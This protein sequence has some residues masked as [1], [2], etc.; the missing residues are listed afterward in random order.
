VDDCIFCK[1]ASEEIPA[2][3]IW[4][5]D[6]FVAFL[7]INPFN[8][9][10]TL[11][12]PKKHLESYVFNNEDKEVAEIIVAA[13]KVSKMLEKY[14]EV[15]RIAVIFEGLQVNHLHVKLYPLRKGDSIKSILNSNYPKPTPEELHKLASDIIKK[16]K[17]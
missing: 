17:D 7:D 11:L 10:M 15:D 8:Q 5:D 12:I 2:E 1:I 4:K 13:K 3:I 9:G 6:N 16:N 14:F